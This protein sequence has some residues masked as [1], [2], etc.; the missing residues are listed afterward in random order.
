MW[1]LAS[2]R[3]NDFFYI[4]YDA[5]TYNVATA[6]QL[7]KAVPWKCLCL[8]YFLD[9]DLY[10]GIDI[11]KAGIANGYLPR[12]V[13]LLSLDVAMTGRMSKLLTGN[14]YTQTTSNTYVK[15]VK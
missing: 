2:K 9:D 8:E 5:R 7:I 13:K 14:G 1:L 4:N 3:E 15:I 12:K 11:L 10:T 6:I